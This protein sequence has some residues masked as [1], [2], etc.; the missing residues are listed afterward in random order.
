[1]KITLAKHCKDVKNLSD[2]IIV[3]GASQ[4]EHDN[5][6]PSSTVPETK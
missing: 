2:D 3:Y 1:M 6:Q 4:T 5:K